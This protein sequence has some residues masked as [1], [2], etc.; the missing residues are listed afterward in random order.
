MKRTIWAVLGTTSLVA[1]GVLYANRPR[2]MAVSAAATPSDTI[3]KGATRVV[4]TTE[5]PDTKPVKAEAPI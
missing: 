3:S 4:A 1:A 5:S 2:I